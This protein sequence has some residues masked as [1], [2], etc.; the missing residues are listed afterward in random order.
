MRK[1][2]IA[3]IISLLVFC[4]ALPFQGYAYAS[5]MQ[6]DDYLHVN[7]NQIVDDNGN[8]VHLTGIA[9]FGL[10]TPNYTYHGIWANS[11][12][13]MLDIVADNGFNLLRAPLSVEL[14]NQWRKGTYPQPESIDYVNNPNLKGKNS[15]EVFDASVAYCKKIGLKVMLDMHRI[16]LY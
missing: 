4:T 3:L 1:K 12:E 13:N 15:L 8:Q 5:D 9:W 10:E 16:G 7:G 14:V 2:A 6:S 11:M